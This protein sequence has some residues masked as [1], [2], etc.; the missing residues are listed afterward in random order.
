MYFSEWVKATTKETPS[1]VPR[2]LVKEILVTAI[3]IAV[4]QAVINPKEAT[5]DISGI[6]RIYLNRRRYAFTS[7]YQQ[8][9]DAKETYR[10]K[11]ELHPYRRLY[12]AVNGFRD[13]K[14]L[15][16]GGCIPLYPEYNF[17]NDGTKKKSRGRKKKIANEVPVSYCVRLSDKYKNALRKA[18]KRYLKENT[19]ED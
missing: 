9:L 7:Q 16:I 3:R 11:F 5:L 18:E 14:E 6:A 1:S 12:E 15:M 2:D 13:V 4:E 17:N 10:W 19:P 8:H